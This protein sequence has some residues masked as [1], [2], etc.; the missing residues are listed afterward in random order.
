MLEG[1]EGGARMSGGL[2]KNV[3]RDGEVAEERE[4]GELRAT[5]VLCNNPSHVQ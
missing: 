2:S 1:W 3:V 5:F 4:K